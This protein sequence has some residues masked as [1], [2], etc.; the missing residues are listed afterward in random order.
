[1]K[2]KMQIYAEILRQLAR[3]SDNYEEPNMS[4]ME[5]ESEDDTSEMEDESSSADMKEDKKEYKNA[6]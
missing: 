6:E 5:S 2:A 3:M 4:E 1:M